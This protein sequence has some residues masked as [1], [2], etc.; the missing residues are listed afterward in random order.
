MQIALRAGIPELQ[1]RVAYTDVLS[2]YEAPSALQK[3]SIHSH[4]WREIAMK[5]VTNLAVFTAIAMS[6]SFGSAI[7]N[8]DEGLPAERVIAAIQTAVAA[9]PGRITELEVEREDG[10]FI[11]EVEIISAD[12]RRTEVK[13]DP[14]KNEA[15]R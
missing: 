3:M 2:E 9:H 10:R 1:A 6:L 15:M 12:G 5:I 4:L 11:V 7:A 13:V 8:D 14:E